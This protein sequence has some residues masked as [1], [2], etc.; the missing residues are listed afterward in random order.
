MKEPRRK[1]SATRLD[2][3]PVFGI[4]GSSGA[5]KTTLIEALIPRLKQDGL[6]VAIVKHGAHN[7]TIDAPGKDSDRFFCAGAD[8][9][10]YGEEC[11]TR[12]H[13]QDGFDFIPFLMNLCTRYDLVLVEGHA[14]TPIPKIW[15]LGEGFAAPPENKGNIIKTFV[16]QEAGVEQIYTFLQ[17]WLGNK[18]EKTPV[19]GCVLIGGKSSRMGHPK[20]LIK[21]NG[22][23]WLE[24]AVGKL[25]KVTGQVVVSGR[26]TIPEPLA[27][28]T[29]V[30]DV[31]GLAGPLAGILSVMR[32][33][34]AASWL[35]M[36]CDQPD[37]ELQSLEWLLSCRK[38]GTRA[39]M[40]DLAGDGR[41]DPLLAWYDFRCRQELE[42]IANSG[43][44]RM[45]AL[46][47][48]RGVSHPRPPAELQASWRNVN[49][50]TDLKS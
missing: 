29:R 24:H 49:T 32:W 48:C 31:P 6:Q 33:Q 20:H 7:V 38:P 40:P 28:L 23:T 12:W 16:R 39:I 37:V 25:A 21:H 15:L 43:E 34:P 1:S 11:F 50:P 27:H 41:I 17:T 45:S 47:G 22:Q 10:L 2:R 44:L 14:S 13:G 18:Q 42:I 9:S 4:C 8:V 30:P 36:A 35:I 3:Y 5:G 19:F 26:G 46:A